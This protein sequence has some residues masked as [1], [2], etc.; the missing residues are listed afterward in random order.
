MESRPES[1]FVINFWAEQALC[2]LSHEIS[3][4]LKVEAMET[5]VR[6]I[7]VTVVYKTISGLG[8]LILS[9]DTNIGTFPF[10]ATSRMALVSTHPLV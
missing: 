3:H 5:C 2:I 9:S 10:I 6:S 7:I 4:L 8:D 1:Y